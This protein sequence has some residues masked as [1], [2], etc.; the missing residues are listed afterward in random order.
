MQSD[1]PT[2]STRR[3]FEPIR[4][5]RV[6]GSGGTNSP[7]FPASTES[8]GSIASPTTQTTFSH[9][10]FKPSP[11]HSR[12]SSLA[13]VAQQGKRLSLNF[14]LRSPTKGQPWTETP[15]AS[16]ER[17]PSP[18]EGNF[19]TVL[20]AQERKVLELKEELHKAEQELERL[21]KHWA[22]HEAFKKRNDVRQMQQLQPINA[23]PPNVDSTDDDVDGSSM[24][25]QKEMERRKALLS[26]VKPSQ[27]TVFSG[28]RHTRT[29]SLLSPDK[30]DHIPYFPP[31]ADNPANKPKRPPLLTRSSTTSDLAARIA[32]QAEL[33]A[34]ASARDQ[35]RDALLRTGKQMASDFKDGLWTFIEDIRQA[36]VGEEGINGT[37]PRTAQ[38]AGGQRAIKRPSHI[39]INPNTPSAVRM[40]NAS[41]AKRPPL[42]KTPSDGPLLSD[43]AGSFW[44]ERGLPEPTTAVVT[45][46]ARPGKMAK[47][48]K[49]VES[50]PGPPREIEDDWNEWGTPIRRQ[51]ALSSSNDSISE[52]LMSPTS[53]HSSPRTSM[54]G[55]SPK[56][57]MLLVKPR[58]SIPWPALVKLSPS[59]LKRTASHLMSEWEKSLTPSAEGQDTRPDYVT[60]SPSPSK[61]EKA[62]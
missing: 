16:P 42:P 2:K 36:T 5:G 37:E 48:I 20:A 15:V 51:S 31:P 40:S 59:N 13:D 26:G 9:A 28:S 19:L 58:D 21:K 32:E 41:T 43:I 47:P 56:P 27:R 50:P 17:L 57:D 22:N 60:M 24:W 45:K 33:G 4:V 38:A 39:D 29:L 14:P 35:S 61:D 3:S 52:Q 53:I 55:L 8:A 1:S 44:R 6:L 18:T 7:V 23:S 12:R 11:S 30:A 54:D 49:S 25:L 46:M 34:D 10:S 62:S